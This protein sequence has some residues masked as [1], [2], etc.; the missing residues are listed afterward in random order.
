MLVE[1]HPRSRRACL[2]C[3]H[4]RRVRPCRID[5]ESEV[6]AERF[7]VR[8]GGSAYVAQHPWQ[9]ADKRRIADAEK[10]RRCERRYWNWPIISRYSMMSKT[11]VGSPG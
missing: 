7:K 6:V 8:R 10:S 1:D 5:K 3:S 2:K 9:E 4:T 11:V